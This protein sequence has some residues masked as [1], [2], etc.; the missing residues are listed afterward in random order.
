L[1][2]SPTLACAQCGRQRV[3][4]KLC[5]SSRSM[6]DLIACVPCV[7]ASCEHRCIV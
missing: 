5:R 4:V 2:T 1:K 6:S 3:R 7:D